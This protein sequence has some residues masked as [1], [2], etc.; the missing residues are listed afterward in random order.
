[1]ENQAKEE[2]KKKKTA[3]RKSAKE[4]N[5]PSFSLGLSPDTNKTRDMFNWKMEDGKKY[6]EKKQYKAFSDTMKNEFKKD[7]EVK[8]LKDL[9]MGSTVIID[10]SK[11]PMSYE[12]KY[13]KDCDVLKNM[14]SMYLKEVQ[15]PK[16]KEVLN[17]KPT[18][19]RPK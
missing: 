15:H 5:P 16:A 11:T 19:L 10:N 8:K 17:K 7:N 4:M 14:F 3:K 13:K 12:A 1:M 18:I 2:I 6:D 9:E